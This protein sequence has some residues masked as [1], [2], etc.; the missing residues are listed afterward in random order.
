MNKIYL[1]GHIDVPAER[2]AD[3]SAALPAHVALT[4]AETGCLSFNVTP[5]TTVPGR[6]L[7][8]EVFSD[9]AAFDAHQERTRNSDWFAVTEGI[10]RDYTIRSGGG[11]A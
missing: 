10:P 8:S 5:C 3:V 11:P 2:M 6:F 7:V 9:R 4:R 1:D